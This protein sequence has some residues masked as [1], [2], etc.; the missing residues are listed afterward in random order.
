MF[1]AERNST[2]GGR[3]ER[4]CE[5]TGSAVERDMDSSGNVTT[6][7]LPARD[8]VLNQGILGTVAAWH[9]TVMQSLEKI[10]KCGVIKPAD[11]EITLGEKPITWF[12]TNPVWENTVIKGYVRNGHQELLG[13][14]GLLEHGHGI[15]RIGIAK[16]TAPLRWNDLREQSE[17]P[18]W[19]ASSLAKVARR[20][21]AKPGEWR[22]TFD[23]VPREKWLTIETYDAKTYS[24]LPFYSEARLGPQAHRR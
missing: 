24:W 11:I 6:V 3:E 19:F 9:Y 12:S 14:R 5:L 8:I 16:E 13:M 15:A 17:M 1:M 23:A 7:I 21:N 22:G 4:R 18:A 20:W 2:L 10:I